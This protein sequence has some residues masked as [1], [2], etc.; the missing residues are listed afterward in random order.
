MRRAVSWASTEITVRVWDHWNVGG[1]TVV[2]SD[3][4]FQLSPTL[5]AGAWACA[6]DVNRMKLSSR[7]FI[8]LG[9]MALI[10]IGQIIAS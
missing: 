3:C 10:N 5:S 1:L 6:N 2:S 8:F 9:K 4:I 7:F